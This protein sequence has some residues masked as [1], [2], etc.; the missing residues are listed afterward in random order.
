MFQFNPKL[1]YDNLPLLPPKAEKIETIK[2]LLDNT[3]EKVKKELPKIY[4]KEPIEELFVHPYC[5]IDFLTKILGVERKTA[6]RYL[7][8]L[9]ENG[10]LEEYKIGREKI[11]INTELF[12]MLKTSG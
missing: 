11:Y 6:S 8:Q 10:I 3:I 12:N 7:N 9:K 1:P 5:K 4:S 2:I